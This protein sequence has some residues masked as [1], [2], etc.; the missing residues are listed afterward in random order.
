MIKYKELCKIPVISDQLSGIVIVVSLIS[1][2]HR[3]Y[4]NRGLVSDSVLYMV[5]V[6]YGCV[7]PQSQRQV[8]I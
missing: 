2:D 3:E 8:G 5:R 7:G 4:E 1:V 6:L